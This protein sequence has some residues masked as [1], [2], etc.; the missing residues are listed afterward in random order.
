M[1]QTLK[2]EGMSCKHCEMAVEEAVKGLAGVQ[3]VKVD[4]VNKEVSVTGSADREQIAKA[5]QEAGYEVVD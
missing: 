3:N 5:I 1:N 4:L 2:V